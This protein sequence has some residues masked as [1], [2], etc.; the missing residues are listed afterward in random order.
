[1]TARN[2]GVAV[3]FEFFPPTT[4]SMETTLWESIQHLSVL[5]PRFVS[6]TYGA[7]GSTRE[8]THNAV[9]RILGETGLTAAPR[10][11]CV[12]NSNFYTPNRYEL[13]YAICHAIGVRPRKVA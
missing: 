13:N 9:S 8:R 6:V 4:E 3:S 11:T 12:V 1:M 5:E 7:D 2:N 10:L